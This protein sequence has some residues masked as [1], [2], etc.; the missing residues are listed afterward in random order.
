MPCLK[1]EIRVRVTGG[2]LLLIH[3]DARHCSAVG[4]SLGFN[5]NRASM[6]SFAS[7][8]IESQSGEG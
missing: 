7:E 2:A 3:G 1:L 5:F 6:N 8:D 4:R